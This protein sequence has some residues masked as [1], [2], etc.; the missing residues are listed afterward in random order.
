MDLEQFIVSSNT[1]SLSSIFVTLLTTLSMFGYLSLNQTYFF[2]KNNKI[3][4]LSIKLI[5]LFAYVF[6]FL[7][8][9][10]F[11]GAITN[12]F[13]FLF[14]FIG[15]LIFI[16]TFFERKLVTNFKW[17]VFSFIFVLIY[18]INSDANND[19]IYHY[20]HINL[21]KNYPISLFVENMS[22][23][24]IKFN[25]AYILLNSVTYIPPL[26]ITIKFENE[27]INTKDFTFKNHAKSVCKIESDYLKSLSRTLV[28]IFYSVEDLANFS[29]AH[30]LSLNVIML[31]GV[32]SFIF[33]L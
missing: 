28:S 6:I 31:V 14:Y 24:R 1:V 18:S 12:H 29:L 32:F 19:F 25:S 15:L 3:N 17:I 7:A 30:S 8:I 23:S 27:V 9:C 10:S 4:Y 16:I 22:D 5:I 21:Y 2:G 13:T 11:Y 26:E 20:D 33:Y